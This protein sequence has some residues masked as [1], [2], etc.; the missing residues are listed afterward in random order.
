MLQCSVEMSEVQAHLRVHGIIVCEAIHQTFPHVIEHAPDGYFVARKTIKV[1]AQDSRHFTVNPVATDPSY[2]C[3]HLANTDD[4][5]Q[6]NDR[7]NHVV[8]D[9]LPF[10]HG[11]N[12]R[13]WSAPAHAEVWLHATSFY[14]DASILPIFVLVR[15]SSIMAGVGLF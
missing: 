12:D 13:L 14:G 1:S 2:D 4:C 8:H 15:L 7:C 6:H 5:Q 11:S 9:T 10:S 3:P